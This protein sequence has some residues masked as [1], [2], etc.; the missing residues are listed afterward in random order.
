MQSVAS[1]DYLHRGEGPRHTDEDD[2]EPRNREAHHQLAHAGACLQNHAARHVWQLEP[3]LPATKPP[4]RR[5]PLR[6]LDDNPTATPGRHEAL[7]SAARQGSQWAQ[8][9]GLPTPAQTT[10]D[11]HSRNGELDCSK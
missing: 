2:V 4:Q 6:S 5:S 1:A 3:P 8:A 9:G 7:A 10:R 11:N